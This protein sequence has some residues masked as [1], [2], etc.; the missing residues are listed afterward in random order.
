MVYVEDGGVR[1]RTRSGRLVSASLPELGALADL[2]PTGTILDGEL[3]AG[4]GKPSDFYEIAPGMA[5]RRRCSAFTFAAFDIPVVMG[6]D[7]T[8][9]P[10][11]DRRRVLEALD[12]AGPA[13][14]TVPSFDA[15]ADQV[16]RV[17]ERLE[18]EGL[19]LKRSDST[20]QPGTRSRSWVKLKCKAWR[21]GHGPLRHER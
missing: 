21:E 20:Y 7:V 14:T 11:V 13:W 15:D 19:V 2:V 10:Y 16:L 6:E 4:A 12:L 8:E 3:V 18:L 17:C 5:S 9:V 1:V